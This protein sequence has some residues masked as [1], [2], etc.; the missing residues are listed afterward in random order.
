M[1]F[2]GA[3][4]GAGAAGNANVDLMSWCVLCYLFLFSPAVSP[5]VIFLLSHNIVSTHALSSLSFL[6][7]L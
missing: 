7:L 3:M 4:G 5:R 6:L 2:G 1:D